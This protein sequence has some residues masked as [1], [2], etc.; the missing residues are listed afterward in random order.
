[1]SSQNRVVVITGAAEGMGKSLAKTYLDEGNAVI[2]VDINEDRLQAL[3]EDFA[4]YGEH[5]V[6]IQADVSNPSSI[7]S[8]AAEV[9]RKFGKVDVLINNAGVESVGYLWEISPE[10]WRKVQGVNTDGAFY[11]VRS[12]VPRMGEQGSPAQ[13]VNI[14]SVAAVTNSPRNG[15][16]GVSKHAVQALTEILY[17]E[18]KEKYPNISVSVVCPAAVDSRIFQDALTEG[19]LSSEDSNKELTE[20]QDYLKEHGISVDEA[21]RRIRAGI[22]SQEFWI[23]THPERF[24]ELARRRATFLGEQQRPTPNIAEERN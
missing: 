8:L 14:S 10:T 17:V 2:G 21:A 12:F 4:A 11:A 6:R 20:M 18:C 13:V 22:D 15:A 1:M 16:Y 23:T 9:F 19:E 7:E 3:G 24:V 5:L